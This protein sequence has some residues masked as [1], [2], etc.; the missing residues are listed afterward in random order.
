MASPAVRAQRV[1]S[2]TPLALGGS[3]PFR[4]RRRS[5]REVRGQGLLLGLE[6]HPMSDAASAHWNQLKETRLSKYLIPNLAGMLESMSTLYWKYA[7]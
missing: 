7:V 2:R 4:E 5:V 6:F 1:P 3:R